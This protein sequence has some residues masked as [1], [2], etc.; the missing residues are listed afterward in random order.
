MNGFP[1]QE[2]TG[3]GYKEA[4]KTTLGKETRRGGRAGVA[5]SATLDK[6]L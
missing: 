4:S 2:S 6:P 5:Q 3:A 1:I